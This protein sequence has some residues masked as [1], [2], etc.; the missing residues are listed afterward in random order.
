MSRWRSGICCSNP[1]F[2]SITTGTGFRHLQKFELQMPPP[3]TGGILLRALAEARPNFLRRSPEVCLNDVFG[4]NIGGMAL[5]FQAGMLSLCRNVWRCHVCLHMCLQLS[6]A[7]PI[8]N[9]YLVLLR[10]GARAK[11]RAGADSERRTK[12]SLLLAPPAQ[13][14]PT[15]AHA[16]PRREPDKS[17]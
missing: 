1:Y 15:A 8:F 11:V 5:F 17:Y 13:R 6:T 16:Q 10:K 4:R 2:G 9:R 3:G 14:R 12:K 7:L